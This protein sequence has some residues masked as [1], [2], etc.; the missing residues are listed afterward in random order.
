[1]SIFTLPFAIPCNS[2]RRDETFGLPA[3]CDLL[4]KAGCGL[5]IAHGSFARADMKLV[6]WVRFNWDLDKLPALEALLPEHYHFAS[7]RPAE[8]KELRALITRSFVHDS[9][10]GDAIHEVNALVAGWLERAFDPEKSGLCLALRHGTRMIGAT[11][12]VSY[13]HLT[14]PTS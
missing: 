6:R 11:I 8:E 13:T 2:R 9:S 10:W 5:A 14:L 12:P 1:M 4:G 7:V 3:V